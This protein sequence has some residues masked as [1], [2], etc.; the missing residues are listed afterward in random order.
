MQ[1]DWDSDDDAGWDHDLWQATCRLLLKS[2]LH[3]VDEGDTLAVLFDVK[4]SD[5]LRD[6][7]LFKAV[8][9]IVCAD[10]VGVADPQL[11]PTVPLETIA[12]RLGVLVDPTT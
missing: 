2:K 7:R 9:A 11:L 12:G 5:L 1:D 6:R 8:L 4:K 10:H 3:L